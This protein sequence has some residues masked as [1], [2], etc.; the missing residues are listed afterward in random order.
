MAGEEIPESAAAQGSPVAGG[1]VVLIF[2][3]IFGLVIWSAIR[4]AKSGRGGGGMTGGGFSGGQKQ[5]LLIARALVRRPRVL[6]FDEATSA[7]D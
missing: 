6:I 7:L 3:L 1:I 5:K 4:G 2:I